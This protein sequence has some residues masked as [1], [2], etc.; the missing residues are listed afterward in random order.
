MLYCM[1]LEV[2][3]R[4]KGTVL[5][6]RVEVADTA[7]AR[8]RGLLGSDGWLGR[9]GLLLRPCRNIHTVGMRYPIDVAFLDREGRVLLAL[10]GMAPGRISPLVLKARCALEL[11]SGRLRQ[12]LTEPGDLLLLRPAPPSAGDN[13][14]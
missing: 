3:N 1:Y 13:T 4:G 9:D 12:T 2:I 7:R 6:S 10:E 14:R 11:P 5:G 8:T